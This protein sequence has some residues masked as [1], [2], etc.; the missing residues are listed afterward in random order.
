MGQ[1]TTPS[2]YADVG[3]FVAETPD[4]AG[5]R[6]SD[7]RSSDSMGPSSAG[8][9][10][11]VKD[12]PAVASLPQLWPSSP[13]DLFQDGT[14]AMQ[15][16]EVLLQR[17]DRATSRRAAAELLDGPA[18]I[19]DSEDFLLKPRS[20]SKPSADVID[21]TTSQAS[22][23]RSSSQ[24]LEPQSRSDRER[25]KY[26]DFRSQQRE[27]HSY[28]DQ[29]GGME[30]QLISMGLVSPASDNGKI[31]SPEQRHPL[32]ANEAEGTDGITHISTN[33]DPRTADQSAVG[34]LLHL[35]AT[36][37]TAATSLCGR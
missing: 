5:D 12:T 25:A 26:P 10:S 34:G 37:V 36:V 24:P 7:D 35:G 22:Q 18:R 23:A 20:G 3:T 9:A 13:R 14:A 33:S 4:A 30:E 29:P 17:N 31:T 8:W 15:S 11:L 28:E 21:L 2:F 27:S 19:P 16:G 32:E 6:D 1:A